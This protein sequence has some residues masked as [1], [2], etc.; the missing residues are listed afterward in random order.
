MTSPKLDALNQR[1]FRKLV[2]SIKA[3]PQQLDLLLAI[4]DDRNLQDTLISAYETELHAQGI[5]PFRTR[6]NLQQPSLHAA[7]VA[8][9]EQEPRLQAREPAV[10]TV[11]N[12]AELLGIRLTD[13]KSEQER[14]FFSLQWTREALRQFSFP[15]VLWLPDSLA[16]RLAQQAPDFWS[17]RGGVFEFVAKEQAAL[18]D[19]P[20]PLPERQT[21]AESQL[22]MADLQQQIVE[23]EATAPA[24]PLL[25]TL[26]NTLGKAYERQYAYQ[27]AL[28][29][30]E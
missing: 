7:L 29:L 14:F 27:P 11:L 24:A 3:N 10:V 5:T 12:A 9:V 1:E 4:C 16:T 13:E 28:E 26:Y 17:W 30:Y 2:L 21:I 19:R 15:V 6:L 23:L 25:V 20:Q 18:P 22:S 8:L